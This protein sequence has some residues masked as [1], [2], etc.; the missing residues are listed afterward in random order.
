LLVPDGL[1]MF[2]PAKHS[3]VIIVIVIFLIVVTVIIIIVFIVVI[4][5]ITTIIVIIIIIVVVVIIVI[6]IIIV[7]VVVVVLSSSSS[8]RETLTKSAVVSSSTV[9]TDRA[10]SGRQT[11]LATVT[12]CALALHA[13]TVHWVVRS[14]R[15]GLQVGASLVWAVEAW[16]AGVSAITVHAVRTCNTTKSSLF[17]L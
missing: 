17:S 1:L 3:I 11:V 6:I 2:T 10:Q 4:I 12:L 5:V 15:T 9:T 16:Q 7:V 13:Q 14:R 8:H